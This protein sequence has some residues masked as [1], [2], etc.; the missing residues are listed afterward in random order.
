MSLRPPTLSLPSAASPNPARCRPRGKRGPCSASFVSYL[1]ID[2]RRL[3]PFYLFDDLSLKGRASRIRY[4]MDKL[5]D[6][7]AK[8]R[9]V[10]PPEPRQ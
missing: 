5:H 6:R 10:I 8:L 2:G 9:G 4:E 3:G 7:V 1:D